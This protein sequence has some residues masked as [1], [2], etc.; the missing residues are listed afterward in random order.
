[1]AIDV[2]PEAILTHGLAAAATRRTDA[3]GLRLVE[4]ERPAPP[5]ARPAQVFLDRRRCP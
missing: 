2:L 4:R 3:A 1:M 5:V